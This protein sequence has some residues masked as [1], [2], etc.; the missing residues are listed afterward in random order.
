MAIRMYEDNKTMTLCHDLMKNLSEGDK[1]AYIKRI[2]ELFD[3]KQVSEE[4]EYKTFLI[5]K[6]DVCNIYDKM[7]G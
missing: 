5:T 3:R 2:Q 1:A 7:Y 4:G 6:E